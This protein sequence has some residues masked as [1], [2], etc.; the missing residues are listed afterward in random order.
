[1]FTTNLLLTVLVVLAL[2]IYRDQFK[3]VFTS[4]KKRHFLMKL[5][6]ANAQIWDLEFQKYQT[7]EMREM[8]RLDRDRAMET[9]DA[10]RVELERE[11]KEE[12]KK[13]LEAKK[14]QAE[15]NAK[16]FGAQMEMLDGEV[17]GRPYV[18]DENP[19]KQGINDTIASIA[20]VRKMFVAYL[21][22]L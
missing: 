22:R 1:M 10:F 17:N 7:L 5:D 11:H 14:L 8:I 2:F 21:A 12:T 6:Q 15:D 18:N 13:E 19:G 4:P 9:A 3:K 16:R 20:E